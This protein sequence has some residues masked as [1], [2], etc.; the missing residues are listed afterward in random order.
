MGYTDRQGEQ[1]NMEHIY[2]SIP[3]GGNKNTYTQSLAEGVTLKPFTAYFVQAVD[4]T[5]GQSNTLPLTYSKTQR[6][7]LAP[8][9]LQQTGEDMLVELTLANGSATDNAGLWVGN[10]H[11]ADYEIGRDLT[12]MYSADRKPQLYT[13]ALYGRMAYQALPDA[14]AHAIPLGIYVP[15]KGDYTL[16]LNRAVSR[17]NE[18]ESVCLLYEGR[19]VA[20]LLQAGYTL[21]AAGK[22]LVDGYTL[23]IRRS[24]KVVTDIVPAAG[25]A[26]YLIVRSG[27]LT[28]AN[29]PAEAMVQV[30][31]A[32]GRICFSAPAGAQTIDVAAP[33]TGVYTVVVTTGDQSY[34]LKTLLH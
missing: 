10:S 9:R 32:L 21:T 30:Y 5:N 6:L 19:V 25:D 2:V 22:G 20:D 13:V 26:P 3:D 16:S 17:V 12:K 33:Q 8:Q 27:M 29:L 31:D 28:I 15:A 24:P 11:T 18:A 7:L 14:Q 1:Q 23:D 34:I 4:P